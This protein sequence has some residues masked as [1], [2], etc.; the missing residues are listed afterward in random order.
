MGIIRR[1]LG[2]ELT[3]D[4]CEVLTSHHTRADE[5]FERIEKG[6]RKREA[7]VE[8][9]NLLA[10]HATVEEKIFYPGVMV[11]DTSDMLHESVEEHLSIKRLLADLITMQVTDESF[12]AKISVLKEQVSHHAHKEEEAKLFPKVKSLLSA[13]ERAALGNQ[14][15]EMFETL[16]DQSPMQ[17]V[18]AETAKAAD[19][20]RPS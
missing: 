15:V 8:L 9:A 3:T 2:N 20:P 13:D 1:I 18:P 7:F 6:E 10:A 17:N 4:V 11:K 12:D 5:L 14:L 19:L 16:I